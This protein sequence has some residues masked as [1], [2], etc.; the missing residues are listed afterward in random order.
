[1]EAGAKSSLALPPSDHCSR[2][3]ERPLADRIE[4]EVR[5]TPPQRLAF[6][7]RNQADLNLGTHDAIHGS[8]RPVE[9]GRSYPCMSTLRKNAL[10]GQLPRPHRAAPRGRDERHVSPSPR[11]AFLG[12]E[13]IDVAVVGQAQL[14]GAPRRPPP[15]LR[16]GQVLNSAGSSCAPPPRTASAPAETSPSRV[17][18]SWHG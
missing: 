15:W 13:G 10:R 11:S 18:A 5:P 1:V 6:V 16:C 17:T 7:Q 3:A 14:D 8:R 12:K 4:G 9:D 2:R